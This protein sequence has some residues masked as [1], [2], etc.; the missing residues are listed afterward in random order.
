[1]FLLLQLL[2]VL[3]NEKRF[4]FKGLNEVFAHLKALAHVEEDFID[5]LLNK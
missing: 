2:E 1:M 3:I 4:L 5:V